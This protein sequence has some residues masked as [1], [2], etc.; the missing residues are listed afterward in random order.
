VTGK[1]RKYELTDFIIVANVEELSVGFIVQEILDLKWIEG[2]SLE[3][4][5]D[6]PFAAY[7]IGAVKIDGVPVLVLSA[8]ALAHLSELPE[9]LAT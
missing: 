6:V 9:P 7:L 4:A 8:L 2:A 1:P 5:P 3:Q